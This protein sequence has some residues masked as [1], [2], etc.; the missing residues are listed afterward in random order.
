MKWML[1]LALVVVVVTA[2][3]AAFVVVAPSA[4]TSK[5][6]TVPFR[7]HRP[8]HVSKVEVCGF[9]DCRRVGGGK[10]LENL[11]KQVVEENADLLSNVVVEGCDCQGECGYGPNLVVDGQIVNGVR[12]KEA[13]LEALGVVVQEPQA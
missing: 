10:K 12:G 9:K 6:T 8:L 2:P 1:L 3:V 4:R 11:V 13:V 7:T 5:A